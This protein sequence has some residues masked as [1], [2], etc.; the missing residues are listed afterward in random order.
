MKII[1]LCNFD[2]TNYTGKNRATR[3]KLKSLG[4]QVDNLIIVSSKF[5]RLKFLE[6]FFLE[7]KTIF[8]VLKNSPDIVISRGFVGFFVQKIAKLKKI[9]TIREVH[10]D[11]LGEVINLGL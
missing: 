8:L 7:I 9:K 1:Y 3:Q 4:N 2:L 5:R 11:I 10:S 6:L